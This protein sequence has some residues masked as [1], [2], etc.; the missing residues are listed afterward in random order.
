PADPDSDRRSFGEWLGARPAASAAATAALWD[1]ILR[2]T[3]NLPAEECSLSM[4]AKVFRTGLFETPG[5]GDIGWSR[6][7]LWELHGS[8]ALAALRRAGATVLTGSTAG[9]VRAGRGGR[10]VVHCDGTELDADAVVLAVPH[11]ALRGLLPGGALDVA[12]EDLGSSPVVNVQVVY[13]RR[14]TELPVAAALGSPVQ[15]VFDRTSATGLSEGQ[16]LGVSLSAADE[17]LGRR[18]HELVE[19]FTVA[20]CE[21]FPSAMPAR[22]LDAVVTKERWATFAARPGTAA[23]RPGTRTGTPGLFLAGSWTDTGWP[24]TME[25]AVRSGVAAARAA[26]VAVDHHRAL[27]EEVPA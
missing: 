19:R 11:Q 12:V 20:L 13:D 4:A 27:P 16:C 2:P 7:P 1:L 22:V 21:L 9:Q 26:L 18:P 23:L 5:G 17:W 25:G 6:V 10:L 14:V 15:W 24:A 8:P 3:C